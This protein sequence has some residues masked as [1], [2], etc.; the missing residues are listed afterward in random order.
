MSRWQP[1]PD[2]LPPQA[3][4]LIE[5]LRLY[6]DRAGLSLASLAAKT[7]YSTTSWHRYLNG[8]KLPP[9][10]A[11]KLLGRL[12]DA[13]QGRLRV[14]WE[15]AAVAWQD[16]TTELGGTTDGDAAPPGASKSEQAPPDPP[17]ST[18]APGSPGTTVAAVVGR[19]VMAAGAV[20]GAGALFTVLALLHPWTGGPG[21]PPAPRGAPP[22]APTW[23]WPLRSS[24]AGAAGV[25]C[26]GHACQGQDPY[27]ER[28]DRFSTVVHALRTYG[29]VLTLRYSPA[30]HTVWAEAGPARGTERLLVAAQGSATQH[31]LPGA[32]RTAMTVATPRGALACLVISTRG[33]HPDGSDSAGGGADQAVDHQLCVTEHDSWADPVSGG[34][35]PG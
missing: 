29:T 33:D 24:D 11:V 2:E 4:R 5:E 31:A 16:K 27:R 6:K 28:C 22:G 30:C 34:S 26:R 1:L 9:W 20:I 14:L 21:R 19:R 10:R 15:S 8:H 13:D 12:A 32:S 18:P 23:P 17:G 7:A 25:G 3:S 35:S